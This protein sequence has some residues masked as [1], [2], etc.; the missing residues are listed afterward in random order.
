MPPYLTRM[1]WAN[2]LKKLKWKDLN[3]ID[4]K[5]AVRK[6]LREIDKHVLQP[7]WNELF[8]NPVAQAYVNF[9][10]T[11]SAREIQAFAPMTQIGPSGNGCLRY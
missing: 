5:S 1:G 8:H 3:I 9:F 6:N 4:K 7:F 11:T 2:D 10:G